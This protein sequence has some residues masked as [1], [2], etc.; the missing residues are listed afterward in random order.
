[1]GQ[2]KAVQMVSSMS[3][4]TARGFGR[5]RAQSSKDSSLIVVSQDDFP[6]FRGR[7]SLAPTV[8]SRYESPVLGINPDPRGP[9]R[10]AC[11]RPRPADNAPMRRASRTA[12]E[13]P[14]E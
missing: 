9:E 14:G 5:L 7:P 11:N 6:G 8:P 2:A 1:M 13:L 12:E 10:G 3:Q 4:T